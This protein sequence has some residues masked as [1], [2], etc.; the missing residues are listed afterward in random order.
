[1]H[2]CL[3]LPTTSCSWPRAPARVVPAARNILLRPHFPCPGPSRASSNVSCPRGCCNWFLWMTRNRHTQTCSN[4]G[5][6]PSVRDLT[7]ESAHQEG[8]G[9][10]WLLMALSTP[11]FYISRIYSSEQRSKLT[12]YKESN[13]R[14]VED[15]SP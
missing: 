10:G 15:R 5:W 12:V 9:T 8:E 7:Q 6:W 4:T 13:R 3:A 2:L 14:E 11:R 1:M